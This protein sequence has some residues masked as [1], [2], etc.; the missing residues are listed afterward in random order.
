MLTVTELDPGIAAG[1]INSAVVDDK[2][3][4][5][6]QLPPATQSGLKISVRLLGVARRVENRS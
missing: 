4:F 2:V 3:R 6:I 5:D 1:M